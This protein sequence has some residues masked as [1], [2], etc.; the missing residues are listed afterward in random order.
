MPSNEAVSAQSSN[1]P[2]Y[3]AAQ[4]AKHDMIVLPFT[5]SSYLMITQTPGGELR[6]FMNSDESSA[7]PVILMSSSSPT[8]Q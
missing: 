6:F 3:A 4:A 7:R 2:A 5:Q 1:A 8:N